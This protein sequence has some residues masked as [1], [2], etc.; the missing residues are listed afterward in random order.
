MKKLTKQMIM[1]LTVLSALFFASCKKETIA[2]AV[3]HDPSKVGILYG[4]LLSD[5]YNIN[6]SV[7]TDPDGDNLVYD[8]YV[9]DKPHGNKMKVAT[10]ISAT[11]YHYITSTTPAIVIIETQDG[12]GGKSTT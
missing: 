5:G 7:A 8:V 6:W 3:N 10:G 2:P 12:K 1:I 11:T 9:M 4:D